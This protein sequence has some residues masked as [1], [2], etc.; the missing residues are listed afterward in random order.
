MPTQKA[1]EHFNYLF[2]IDT[3]LKCMWSMRTYDY[4]YFHSY[5]KDLLDTII[6][7]KVKKELKRLKS[8]N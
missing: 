5:G 8:Q 1:I 6:D 3:A 2:D 4:F 7:Q